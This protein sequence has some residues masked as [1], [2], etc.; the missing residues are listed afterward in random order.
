MVKGEVYQDKF[1]LQEKNQPS[2]LCTND[3]TDLKISEKQMIL[4]NPC[5]D[6]TLQEGSARMPSIDQKPH[7]YLFLVK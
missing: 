5:L 6:T 1:C 2:M 4:V 7:G 3:T